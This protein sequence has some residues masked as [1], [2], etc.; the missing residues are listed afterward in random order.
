MLFD[1]VRNSIF[2]HSNIV[3]EVQEQENIAGIAIDGKVIVTID[4]KQLQNLTSTAP[5]SDKHRLAIFKE[6][7]LQFLKKQERSGCSSNMI[8]LFP[9]LKELIQQKNASAYIV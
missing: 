9:K 5:K 2:I 4:L 7:C 8:E 1:N 3:K 6:L